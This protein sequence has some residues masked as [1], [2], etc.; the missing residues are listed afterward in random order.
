VMEAYSYPNYDYCLGQIDLVA[1]ST[2]DRHHFLG[3]KHL[4]FDLEHQTHLQFLP[5]EIELD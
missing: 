2:M 5:P 3:N 1:P 4:M